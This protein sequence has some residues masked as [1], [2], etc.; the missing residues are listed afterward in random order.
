MSR[1]KKDASAQKKAASLAESLSDSLSHSSASRSV[2]TIL[3]SPDRRG[4]RH[5]SRSRRTAIK[6]ACSISGA[7]LL[8]ISAYSLNN[9]SET[10]VYSSTSHQLSELIAQAQRDNPDV[11]QLRIQQRQ[12]SA[13]LD[14]QSSRSVFQI[15]RVRRAIASASSTSTRLSRMLSD[16]ADGKTWEQAQKDTA[17]GTHL[18]GA[19][20]TSSSG[21][22]SSS[23]RKPGSSSK[24]SG[25]SSNASGKT[26]SEQ[27][28]DQI[29]RKENEEAQ[30][31]QNKLN[32]LLKQ[33]SHSSSG[34][35]V[36]NGNAKPW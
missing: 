31:R 26:E 18:A 21:N 36:D 19:S 34:T 12:V 16:M 11:D 33:N 32:D 17:G 4:S 28:Q 6:V 24:N 30:K 8:L 35:T 3:A 25:T 14:S 27:Q 20:S 5:N 7:I 23:A 1:K 10:L 2:R 29:R 15:P 22:S 13:E 9:W